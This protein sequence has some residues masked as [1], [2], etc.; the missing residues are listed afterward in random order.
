[1]C[2]LQQALKN[3]RTVQP[4]S[5]GDTSQTSLVAAPSAA[6]A[7]RRQVEQLRRLNK[8]KE[9][10]ALVRRT[11]QLRLVFCS[12]LT[13]LDMWIC[14]YVDMWICGYVDMWFYAHT[15]HGH[16]AIWSEM[17]VA[18]ARNTLHW[19]LWLKLT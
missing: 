8:R 11:R 10:S 19:L 13:F 2:E 17:S 4:A 9:K 6:F 5:D 1:M 14:G 16:L 3:A 15:T 12:Y 7:D 18:V